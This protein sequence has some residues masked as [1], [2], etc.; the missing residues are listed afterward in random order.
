MPRIAAMSMSG[1][2]SRGVVAEIVS[3]IDVPRLDRPGEVRPH[4]YQIGPIVTADNRSEHRGDH[5]RA[6]RR[7]RGS[8]TPQSSF[9]SRSAAAIVNS[10]GRPGFSAEPAGKDWPHG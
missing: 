8:L 5:Q 10:H 7:A 6:C 9:I 4:A 2:E 3:G 1:R